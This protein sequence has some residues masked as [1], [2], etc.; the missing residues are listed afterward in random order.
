[1][2]WWIDHKIIKNMAPSHA[3]TRIINVLRKIEVKYFREVCFAECMSV[4]GYP[5]RFDFYFPDKKLL[6]EYDGVQHEKEDAK[7]NDGIKNR[8]A[9]RKGLILVRL[10]R[11]DWG[12][13]E[14]IVLKIVNNYGDICYKKKKKK[15][16]IHTKIKRIPRKKLNLIQDQRR[17]TRKQIIEHLK[18]NKP[19]P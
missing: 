1:M 18:K 17:M 16:K 14:R 4:N 9:K 12:S 13:L 6:I 5:L 3:E 2:K 15:K 10:N 7:E 8:F 19:I 11:L